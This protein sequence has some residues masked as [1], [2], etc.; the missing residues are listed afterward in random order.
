MQRRGFAEVFLGTLADQSLAS[1][2]DGAVVASATWA[3]R[4]GAMPE[5]TFE[6]REDATSK[7]GHL[8]RDVPAA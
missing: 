7:R 5:V 2:R 1:E 3:S 4:S 8:H 6:G